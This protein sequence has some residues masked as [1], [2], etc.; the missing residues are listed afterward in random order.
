M[1]DNKLN[2]IIENRRKSVCLEIFWYLA[3]MT[4]TLTGTLSIVS[5]LMYLHN[6]FN[7]SIFVCLILDI[8][9]PSIY[10]WFAKCLINPI[11][12]KNKE[13]K[14]DIIKLEEE[15]EIEKM[16]NDVRVRFNSLS[17]DKQ[18]QLLQY[19]RDNYLYKLKGFETIDNLE[20]EQ[21]LCIL[22]NMNEVEVNV[23]NGGY[24]RKRIIDSYKI[25]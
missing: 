21:I 20:S 2:K 24:L 25:N 13:L 23:N 10:S 6:F 8:L 7:V 9:L 15:F 18:I 3:A 5:L 12:N 4:L 16:I 1:N 19:M 11:E 17:R 14:K 22:N